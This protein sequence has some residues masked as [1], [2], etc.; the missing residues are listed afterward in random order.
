MLYIAHVKVASQPARSTARPPARPSAINGPPH[1]V[2]DKRPLA[3]ELF[4]RKGME[5]PLGAEWEGQE[6]SER[7]SFARATPS[8]SSG[9]RPSSEKEEQ[10]EKMT[11]TATA[12]A[13]ATVKNDSS[14]GLGGP[15]VVVVFVAATRSSLT[16]EEGS[17]KTESKGRV[18]SERDAIERPN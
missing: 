8:V 11:V 14:P 10:Q 18:H 9:S 16:L 5:E 13:T 12:A 7:N 3:N 4:Q 2:K 1:E 6:N 17:K 15:V